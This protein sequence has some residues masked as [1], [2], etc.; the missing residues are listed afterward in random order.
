MSPAQPTDASEVCS[1]AWSL[2]GVAL[3]SLST[4]P[5]ATAD[6]ELLEVLALTDL[7]LEGVAKVAQLAPG[8][9][10]HVR[11]RLT[12]AAALLER[13]RT[14]EGPIERQQAWSGVVVQLEAARAQIRELASLPRSA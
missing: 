12:E 3:R 9:L 11:Q 1:P 13:D 4:P 2:L 10:A 6:V 8:P 5:E 7:Y 14:E